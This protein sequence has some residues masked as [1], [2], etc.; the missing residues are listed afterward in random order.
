[1]IIP[2]EKKRLIEDTLQMESPCLKVTLDDRTDFYVAMP[3]VAEFEKYEPLS[4]ELVQEAAE[5]ICIADKRGIDSQTE[6]MDYLDTVDQERKNAVLRDIIIIKTDI[7]KNNSYEIH[8]GRKHSIEDEASDAKEIFRH[9]IEREVLPY[10]KS[11]A[12]RELQSY[13]D[14][15]AAFDIY[16]DNN[17]KAFTEDYPT[18]FGALGSLDSQGEID[19]VDDYDKLPDFMKNIVDKVKARAQ[20]APLYDGCTSFLYESYVYAI[21]KDKFYSICPLNIDNIFID[22][23][24]ALSKGIA[25]MLH[26][27]G[28]EHITIYQKW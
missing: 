3:F 23:F 28:C 7:K 5:F 11:W 20:Y 19:M 26:E 18:F 13:L 21:Y 22:E 17:T 6:I 24:E 10:D 2:T 4:P 15:E 12:L 27:G 25:A 1:M 8:F 14:H 16:D 9:S